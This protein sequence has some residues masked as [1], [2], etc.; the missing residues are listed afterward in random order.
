MSIKER[1]GKDVE[2]CPWPEDDNDEMSDRYLADD[3]TYRL[4]IGPNIYL[5]GDYGCDESLYGLNV[6]LA[7]G[8]FGTCIG[9]VQSSM[10][11]D[12]HVVKWT[13]T[14]SHPPG[15][16]FSSTLEADLI[17]AL[18]YQGRDD[19]PSW[20]EE[21]K[22]LEKDAIELI[23]TL[24]S[25]SK[26]TK[27]VN[28]KQP[29]EVLDQDVF[30]FG[31]EKDDRW[32]TT[33]HR[34]NDPVAADR[35]GYDSSVIPTPLVLT[36]LIIDHGYFDPSSTLPDVVD[37]KKIELYNLVDDMTRRINNSLHSRT[38]YGQLIALE[39]LVA[40]HKEKYHASKIMSDESLWRKGYVEA[41]ALMLTLSDEHEEG[42]YNYQ[43]IDDPERLYKICF[44]IITVISKMMLPGG[45]PNSFKEQFDRESD[46]NRKHLKAGTYFSLVDSE[47]FLEASSGGGSIVGENGAAVMMFKECLGIKLTEDVLSAPNVSVA[48]ETDRA[49]ESP[50]LSLK[51]ESALLADNHPEEESKRSRQS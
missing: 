4:E 21:D 20:I 22:R 28:W 32:W 39:K 29:C 44:D 14:G 18:Y 12:M 5:W 15:D 41:Q 6:E 35:Y 36:C 42:A 47:E 40:E 50:E 24:A 33:L 25:S 31:S 48:S 17:L 16:A 23:K 27:L 11:N 2:V 3:L 1:A 10:K 37:K 45:V 51:R 8:N 34:L 7:F 46:F 43:M 9:V 38:G 30:D 19:T 26:E 13:C 49:C